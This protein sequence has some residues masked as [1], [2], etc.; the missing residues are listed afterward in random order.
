LKC[1]VKG[2][3]LSEIKIQWLGKIDPL[4]D[5]NAVVG[6]DRSFYGSKCSGWER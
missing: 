2:A 1:W 3:F 4:T 5:Q 6:K